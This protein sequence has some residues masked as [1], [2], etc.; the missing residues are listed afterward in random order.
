M[1]AR[2]SAVVGQ[3]PM[4]YLTAWRLALAADRLASSSAT[5]AVIATE[6]G[7]SNAFAFSAAFS[8]IYGVSPT[9]Y[10]QSAHAPVASED[11]KPKNALGRH[12]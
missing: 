8:R 3:P 12:Q 10:R 2:F 1:A 5:T 6:V 11:S 4:A 9:G 7:Y